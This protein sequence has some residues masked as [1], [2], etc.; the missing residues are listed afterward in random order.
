MEVI[1]VRQVLFWIAAV[2]LGLIVVPVMRNTEALPALIFA[3]IVL[4]I[5]TTL[6]GTGVIARQTVIGAARLILVLSVLSFFFPLTAKQVPAKL[7]SLDSWLASDAKAAPTV[8]YAAPTVQVVKAG[9]VGKEPTLLT[10]RE[11]GCADYR[12]EVYDFFWYLEGGDAM[13]YPPHGAPPFRDSPGKK[14]NRAL[15][16]GWWKWC[17]AEPDAT[18]VT[19]WQ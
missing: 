10:Y 2:V 9:T 7:N 4:V 12:V 14:E 19:L 16:P 17:R 5:A 3:I 13:V 6:W 18:G 15:K 1:V 8:T 11:D